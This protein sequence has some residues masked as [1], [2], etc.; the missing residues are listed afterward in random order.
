VAFILAA[1]GQGIQGLGGNMKNRPYFLFA[2]VFLF[3]I[4]YRAC[5]AQSPIDAAFN[6]GAAAQETNGYS[7]GY[8]PIIQSIQN[9][10][11][12]GTP[13]PAPET[14]SSSSEQPSSL[15][16]ATQDIK[17]W[18][19]DKIIDPL[20]TLFPG[21]SDAPYIQGLIDTF[22]IATTSPTERYQ[23]FEE[24]TKQLG[25]MGEPAI[26]LLKSNL[27][28]STNYLIRQGTVYAMGQI[29]GAEAIDTLTGL[30]STDKHLSVRLEAVKAL[31][32]I[33]EP[34]KTIEPLIK[35]ADTINTTAEGKLRFGLTV[36]SAVAQILNGCDPADV[37]GYLEEI[38]QNGGKIKATDIL[39]RL[40]HDQ[41]VAAVNALQQ[42]KAS[43]IIL[44]AGAL[45]QIETKKTLADE[46]QS[47]YGITV[48]DKFTPAETKVISDAIQSLPASI[49]EKNGPTITA[50]IGTISFD[51]FAN[52]YGFFI[53]DVTPNILAL[54]SFNEYS[55]YHE[56]GHFIKNRFI[57]NT[58]AIKNTIHALYVKA[59]KN[60]DSRDFY[61]YYD[62]KSEIENF[63]TIFGHYCED[64]KTQLI[65]A[66][67]RAK[68][69]NTMM[70]EK[71]ILAIDALARKNSDTTILY[72]KRAD[73][74]AAKNTK[75]V[76]IERDSTEKII[77]I[78]GI[79]IYN[80]DGSYNL[81]G[82]EEYFTQLAF[83]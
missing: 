2:S 18:T 4:A 1:R 56:L 63:S 65:D 64:T 10:E 21:Q 52:T 75:A 7:E 34:E 32:S 25:K 43:T 61:N 82:L 66:I 16:Q 68:E 41:A 80:T 57:D 73:V 35:A 14:S 20:T 23:R 26:A 51:P 29:E 31:A 46:I 47:K 77:K 27:I 28:N 38:E 78:D 44:P 72:D 54:G 76:S 15:Q 39:Y 49:F 79:D 42:N 24:T 8:V 74:T 83:N 48:D 30:L 81:P 37:P 67:G 22:N 12:A 45:K 62:Q 11:A 40:N 9:S 6:Q 3:F 58:P 71:N 59:D 19:Q 53:Q 70:L 33:G 36:Q 60:K 13:E 55:L 5:E 69:G 17:T 50:Y